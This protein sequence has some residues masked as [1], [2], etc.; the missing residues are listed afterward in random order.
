[1]NALLKI[2]PCKGRGTAAKRWWRGI[3]LS[4]AGHPSDRSATAHLP[5]QGRIILCAALPL[6][7]AS[8]VLLSPVQAK[9][10]PRAVRIYSQCVIENFRNPGAEKSD[11]FD[12][13]L[14]LAKSMCGNLRPAAVEVIA[15]TITKNM[16]S[17]GDDPESAAQGFLDIAMLE[18]AAG[19]WAEK[20]PDEVY[21][22]R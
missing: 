5:L 12:E 20:H 14:E 1:M 7:L 16:K 19:I 3:A 22:G 15:K 17:G 18:Q 13:S 8:P 4:I 9:Q 21:H 2:L 6:L 11:D 10:P